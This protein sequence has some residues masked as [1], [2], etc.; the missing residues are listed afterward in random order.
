MT[1]QLCPT[2]A[3]PWTSASQASPSIEF[4]RQEYWSGL[5]FP[6]PGGLPDPRIEPTSPVSPALAGGLFT[7]EPLGNPHGLVVG[8]VNLF[9]MVVI[10]LN[11]LMQET[12]VH[13]WIGKIPWR[14][15]METHS[16]ILAWKILWTEEPGRLKS[17]GWQSVR[18]D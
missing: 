11:V 16:S 5:T 6:P 8:V 17:M 2:L 1:A 12:W 4:S 15:E 14:K 13:T 3:T 9:I 18:Q 10:L 7:T